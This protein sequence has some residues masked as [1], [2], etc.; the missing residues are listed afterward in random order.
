[1]IIM[2]D[3]HLLEQFHTFAECGTLSSA[4]EKLHTSQP[5]LTR[6][7]KKLEEDLGVTLFIRSKNQLRLNETGLHA[8]R[9]A[10]DVL[11]ADSDFES[12]VKAYDRS[13]HTISIGFCAPVPQT[14]LTPILNTIFEGMT[15]SA[16]MTDDAG[17]VERLKSHEYHLAVL[18]KDPEDEEIYVKKCGH[19]DLFISLMPGD[20]LAFYPEVHLSDLDG[21]T[22]L[23]LTRIG[24]WINFHNNKTPNANYLLQIDMDSFME[25]SQ[26]SNYPS[27]SSS[28]YMSR[29]IVNKGKITIPIVDPECHTD[30]Y[31]ACMA[32]EKERYKSLFERVNDKTI[33]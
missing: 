18:H 4:A 28:Y 21:K 13:L 31:L 9:Y 11:K 8:A 22:I 17:F 27:F 16:D 1:M 7:M 33:L 29:G 14:V 15:I 32:S 25:L 26:N 12:K 6:S 10:E 3:I 30:Y 2:I 23:L 24:F 5:A 19:E 20:P